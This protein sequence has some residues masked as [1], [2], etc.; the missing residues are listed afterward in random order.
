MKVK[1]VKIRQLLKLNLLKSK[2]Y[3]Y[4]VKKMKF[5]NLVDSNLNQIIVNI[6]KVLQIIFQYHQIEKRILFVGL[7]HK[8]E[9]K[10]N[11][12]TRHVA[13]PKTLNV[14]GM[15]SNSDWK[16]RKDDKNLNKT[17]MKQSPKFLLPKLS[18]RLDLIVLFEHNKSRAIFSEAEIAKIPL[19]SFGTCLSAETTGVS[20]RV[21]GNF[22]NVLT[23][24]D[25]NI[26]FMGLNFLFKDLKK[27]SF[28]NSRNK[29][30][31][32]Q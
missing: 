29:N 25:K 12:Y 15:I 28:E 23:A 26:F 20:Y 4:P 2:V 27:R 18:K 5:D 30:R 6:K 31:L 14:Q 11:R 10:I 16:L 13:I 7:P 21:E 19:I 22:K 24:P 9:S 1:K 17:W 3:E 8:L 32:S